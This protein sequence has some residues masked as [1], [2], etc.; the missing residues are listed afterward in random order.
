MSE[1]SKGVISR[2]YKDKRNVS[3]T[4]SIGLVQIKNR[5]LNIEVTQRLL[6]KS[7]NSLDY[8]IRCERLDYQEL[9][10]RRKGRSFFKGVHNG[11]LST[12]I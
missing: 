4:V 8:S 12:E 6:H 2:E 9:L 7:L 11:P 10:K 1:R 3:S 5:R